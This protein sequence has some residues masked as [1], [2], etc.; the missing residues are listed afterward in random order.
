VNPI[1]LEILKHLQYLKSDLD[2]IQ[3]VTQ[4]YMIDRD[5]IEKDLYDF[6]T[7]LANYK[8]IES[9]CVLNPTIRLQ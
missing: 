4:E 8:L 1:G 3:V 9:T 2:I 7:L 6:K 5:A